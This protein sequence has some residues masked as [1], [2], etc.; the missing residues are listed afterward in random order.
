MPPLKGKVVI[1]TGASSGIGAAAAIRFAR[2]G[3]KMVLAARRGDR[4]EQLSAQIRQAGGQALPVVM[5]VSQPSQIEA[6]VKSALEAHGRIDILLNNAGFGRLD[7]LEA[8]DPVADIQAQLN[9]NLLGVI[10]T[11]RAVLPQMYRQRSGHIIN[12]ASLAGWIAPPLYT[13]YAAGKFG[14]RGFSEA[15]RR[16]AMPM[17]VRVSVIYPGSVRTEFGLHVGDSAAKRRFKSPTWLTLSAD[18]VARAVVGLA[19]YPRREIVTPWFMILA[20][21]L[22]AHLKGLSDRVQAGASGKYHQS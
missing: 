21:F 10:L 1:I 5:D 9:V 13:I 11:A 7:W 18:D 15:L 22:N 12:M 19:R 3:C 16:E 2:E 6:M 14:M 4:L 20:Q 8:L 17:G